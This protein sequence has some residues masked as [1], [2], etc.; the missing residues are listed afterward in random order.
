MAGNT[1]NTIDKVAGVQPNMAIIENQAEKAGQSIGKVTGANPT[2]SDAGV[3]GSTTLA[4]LGA[5]G[6]GGAGLAGI[7]TGAATKL[8]IS[9]NPVARTVGAK[10]VP[11]YALYSNW[12]DKNAEED[13]KLGLGAVLNSEDYKNAMGSAGLVIKS[14]NDSGGKA[15][16]RE[17]VKAISDTMRTGKDA[18]FL[19][20][21]LRAA[22][23]NDNYIGELKT[24][25]SALV[26]T[27]AYKKH[28]NFMEN[29]VILAAQNSFKHFEKSK[30]IYANITMLK[31]HLKENEL[32][33]EEQVLNALS[34]IPG[35]GWALK[36]LFDSVSYASL[37]DDINL[38]TK[39]C[40]TM[41]MAAMQEELLAA[42]AIGRGIEARAHILGI[43]IR[44]KDGWFSSDRVGD[45]LKANIRSSLMDGPE[46]EDNTVVP[47]SNNINEL[48]MNEM[49][50]DLTANPTSQTQ[51][52]AG[53]TAA[54]TAAAEVPATTTAT[55]PAASA[56]EETDPKPAENQQSAVDATATASAVTEKPAAEVAA[57]A[58]AAAAA[59]SPAADSSS[60]PSTVVPAPSSQPAVPANQQPAAA[61]TPKPAEKPKSDASAAPL[62]GLELQNANV[63]ESPVPTPP[64]GKVPGID[65]TIGF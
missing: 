14:L 39:I 20:R 1:S 59:K 54:A 16:S 34:A 60:A 53:A 43:G 58:A 31:N 22:R 28:Q 33:I 5:S 36:Q 4:A 42:K 50:N 15:V 19:E 13:V 49:D 32:D 65:M 44:G 57:A 11:G 8:K 10:L 40:Q 35:L 3:G 9:D 61:A 26:N 62:T 41:Q 47:S 21:E 37:K 6:A 38:M 29:G 48:D 52:D 64:P 46:I 18:G 23:L 17:V 24:S 7:A 12:Q 63:I 25:F 55:P 51:P 56:T 2:T 45:V 27:T 30:I